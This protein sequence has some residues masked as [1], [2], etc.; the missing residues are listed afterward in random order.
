MNEN[1]KLYNGDCL[2]VMDKLIQEGIKV[3][4]IITSPPYN[5]GKEYEKKVSLSKYLEWQKQVF[6]KAYIL[7]SDNGVVLLNVGAFINEYTNNIPLSFEFYSI[8]TNTG[9][10]L[11]QNIVWHF[12]SGMSASKKLSGRY[13][14]IMWWYKGDNLPTFNLEDIRVKEWKNFDKRNNLNGKNPT[15]VWGINL[16]K[17][18]SKEKKKHPCQFPE[19]LI[20]RLVKGMTNKSEIILDMFMGSGT[21][22]VA[23]VNLNRKFIGI[24]LDKE[25]FDIAKERIE[26][27]EIK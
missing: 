18:N 24:E 6:K 16:V 14:D 8:F 7:L 25:Y 12:P 20:N 15:N 9:Y 19:V 27:E 5:I 22:G 21:T 23:C 1:I 26:K 2:E 17:G 10:K 13:E 11:R 3:D 4:V